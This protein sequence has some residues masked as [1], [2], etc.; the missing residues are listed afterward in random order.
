MATA[1]EAPHDAAESLFGAII[2]VLD[3]HEAEHTLTPEILE[4]LAGAYAAAVTGGVPDPPRLGSSRQSQ[5][6]WAVYRP[7]PVRTAQVHHT[8]TGNQHGANLDGVQRLRRH[9][10]AELSSAWSHQGR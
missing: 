3:K 4:T 1:K 7:R 9:V 8:V 6:G 2:A 5:C 10:P